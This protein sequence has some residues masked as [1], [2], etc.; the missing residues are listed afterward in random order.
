MGI[1]LDDFEVDKDSLIRVQKAVKKA[2]KEKNDKLDIIKI[3][4]FYS[5]KD[6]VKKMKIQAIGRKSLSH[7]SDEGL[8]PDYVKNSQ[9]LQTK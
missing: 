3:K 4:R 2:L 8:Y 9:T 1:Y 7:I 5:S 6:I